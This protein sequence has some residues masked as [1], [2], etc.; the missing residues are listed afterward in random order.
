MWWGPHLAAVRRWEDILS[1]PAPFPGI[2]GPRGGWRPNAR[3]TEWMMG[4]PEGWITDVPGVDNR[5]GVILS[6]NG[7]CPQQAYAAYHWL[8]TQISARMDGMQLAA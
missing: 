1:R 4:K 5:A 2:Q 3:F 6:G 8:L 7:V